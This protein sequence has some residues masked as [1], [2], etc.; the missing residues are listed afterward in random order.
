MTLIQDRFAIPGVVHFEEGP[1]YLVR[2]V[3]TTPQAEAQVYLLGAHASH[4]QAPNEQPVLFMS[5]RS[6]FEQGKPIRG[7]VPVIFPWFGPRQDDPSAPAH[8][9]ARVM[10]WDVEAVE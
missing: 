5:G 8:G 9:F 7:G 1:N 2:A 10:E 6:W 3:I 4:S